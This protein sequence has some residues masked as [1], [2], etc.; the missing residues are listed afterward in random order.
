MSFSIELIKAVVVIVF[1]IVCYLLS[2]LKVDEEWYKKDIP[3]MPTDPDLDNSDDIHWED[4]SRKDINYFGLQINIPRE[5]KFIFVTS[6]GNLYWT[7]VRPHF[8]DHVSHWVT[9]GK[10]Y[11]GKINVKGFDWKESVVEV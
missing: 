4:D 2:K 9:A 10:H 3:G 1:I 6:S 11:M 5:A 7:A 8:S